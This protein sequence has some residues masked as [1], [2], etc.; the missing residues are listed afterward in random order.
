M[1]LAPKV[2]RPANPEWTDGKSGSGAR[3]ALIWLTVL[4][5][6]RTQEREILL[7][8]ADRDF[9]TSNGWHP[10]LQQEIGEWPPASSTTASTN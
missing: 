5:T 3:D 2:S 7:L 8:C 10:E 4:N 6:A 1:M 9:G